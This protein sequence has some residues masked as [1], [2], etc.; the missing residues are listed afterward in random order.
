MVYYVLVPDGYD[1]VDGVSYTTM[2]LGESSFKNFW[3]DQG[4]DTLK[5]IVKSHTDIIEL[6]KIKDEK[7]KEYQIEEFL[8]IIGKLNL[9]R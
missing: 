2:R 8:A 3:S 7:G 5:N 4:F 9:I 1:D 6:V